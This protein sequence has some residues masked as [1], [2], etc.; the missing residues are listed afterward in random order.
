MRFFLVVSDTS[1]T[2]ASHWLGVKRV[3]SRAAK[4]TG[5]CAVYVW[6]VCKS[7]RHIC[8]VVQLTATSLMRLDVH[9]KLFR[10]GSD[11]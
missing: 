9:E 7:L 5:S 1:Y 3:V 11:A 4:R 2:N 6:S 8:V 10:A